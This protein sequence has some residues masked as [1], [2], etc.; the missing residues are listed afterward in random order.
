VISKDSNVACVA[1]A[2]ACTANLAQGLRKEYGGAARSLC[3]ILLDKYKEKNAAVG[4]AATEAL[5]NMHRHCWGL[6]D[7]A[8]DVAGAQ[9]LLLP[10]VAAGSG[11]DVLLLLPRLCSCWR[12]CSRALPRPHPAAAAATHRHQLI[13]ARTH[14]PPLDGNVAGHDSNGVGLDGNVAGL[15][16]N[17]VGLDGNVAGHDSNGVGLDGNVA[18]HDSIPGVGGWG[19]GRK[20]HKDNVQ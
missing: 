15:D 16:S 9:W 2:I 3:S 13:T 4:K 14:Q 11:A 18:G 6:L 20:A 7:V 19:W 1:E 17:G 10:A 8:E 12:C 5:T